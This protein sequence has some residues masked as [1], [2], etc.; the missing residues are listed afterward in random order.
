MENIDGY[1]KD[2]II[3]E[4]FLAGFSY[5]EILAFFSMYHGIELSLRQLHRN[6]RCLGMFRR[7][8]SDDINTIIIAVKREAD[9]P[10]CGYGYR[11]MIH[12]KLIQMGVTTNRET[13]GL[14]LKAVDPDGVM[15]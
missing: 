5:T 6:V 2:S 3:K 7:K 9:T 15:N 4:Y 11:M 13:G 1:C 12:Q 14:I 10:S 8:N